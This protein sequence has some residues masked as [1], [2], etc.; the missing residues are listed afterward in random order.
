MSEPVPV[1]SSSG[2]LEAIA[3]ALLFSTG[4]A[5]IKSSAFTAAQISTLRSGIAA[6]ALLVWL[7]GRV[8]LSPAVVGPAVSYAATVT[9]FVAA[10]RLTTAASAIFLQSLAPLLL[11]PLGP[12]FGERVRLRDAPFLAL[13]IVGLWLCVT[14]RSSTPDTAP[15]PAIGNLLALASAVTW[16]ITLLSLRI[17][18]R[19]PAR[20][21][22]GLHVVVAGNV[23]AALVA[24]PFSWPLPSA[25]VAEW[26]TVAY[27]GVF[28]IATAYLCLTAAVRHLPAIE[29]SLLLLV[30]P[31]L[32]PFWT[33]LVRG[34]HPGQGVM[35]GGV[36]IVA[37]T[38]L[39]TILTSRQISR[40][41]T[42]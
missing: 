42:R 2:R 14:G 5:A 36:V 18:E 39:R 4:G 3:A 25:P 23:V 38:A 16:A 22:E 1:S 21:G 24:L 12:L 9:L 41:R 13:M 33:W 26:A 37:A 40:T 11:V 19:N 17:L 30:E 27:L 20:R 29:V 35:A 8:T 34:E 32:N 7:R 28:Q 31:L 15:D 6:V 10:T